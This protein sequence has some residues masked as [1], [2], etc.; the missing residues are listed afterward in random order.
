MRLIIKIISLTLFLQSL[1]FG[2]GTQFLAI[3][4]NSTE[5]II[6]I[7]PALNKVATNPIITA[8]YGNWLGGIKV[9]SF[10]Y[11]RNALGGSAGFDARYIA[12][13]DIELRS[14]RPTDEP[15]ALYGATAFALDGNFN[16]TTPVGT[17]GIKIRYISLQMLE[18][19][20]VGYAIDLGLLHNISKNIT[21]GFNILNLGSM[22][23]LYRETP[24]LPIRM[25]VGSSYDF[26]FNEIDNSIY[27]ALE[28]STM[29]NGIVIRIGEIVKWNKLQFLLGTQFSEEVASISGGIGIK[30]GVYDIKYGI[31]FG[32]QSLGIPQ[33]LDMSVILP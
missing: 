31:Q 23:A 26:S 20:S 6:G 21:I 32:S 3:P 5:L 2:V 29:T 1:I 9:S 4:Q 7:N 27:V 19:F 28:K 24:K 8:S 10:G 18:E 12:L 14:D 17:L 11:N 22:S 13:N 16:K 33:M 30:L 15:L 25:I